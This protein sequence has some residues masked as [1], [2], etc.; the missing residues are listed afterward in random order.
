MRATSLRVLTFAGLATIA[1]PA[2]ASAGSYLSLG[3]GG[4]PALQG[5]L[6][7]AATG[8][9]GGNGRFALGERFG[10]LAIEASLSRFGLA[11]SEATVAG[12]HLRLAFPLGSHLAAYGRL[13]AERLWLGDSQMTTV[14]GTGSGYVGGGGLEYRVTAPLLGQASLWAELSQD[15]FTTED[16]AEGGVRL[17]TLGASVGL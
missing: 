13:G 15:E 12:I 6:K 2:V 11:D 5:D 8:D 17:W 1:A 9:Q 4:E 16:G 14:S 7:V 10:R 3:L